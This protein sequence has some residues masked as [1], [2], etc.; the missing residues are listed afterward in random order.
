MNAPVR[1]WLLSTEEPPAVVEQLSELLDPAERARRDALVDHGVRAEFVLCRAALRQLLADALNTAPGSLRFEIGP[2][3]KPH[4]AGGAL[5]FN[6]SHSDGRAAI[7]LSERAVGVDI[8]QQRTG[9]GLARMAERYYAPT[10]AAWM[11][12]APDPEELGRRFSRLWSRKEACA[13]VTGGRLIPSLV[14][15]LS[16]FPDGS[17]GW[18]EPAVTGRDLVLSPGIHGA[19][20]MAGSEPF[21]LEIFRWAPTALISLD[22]APMAGTQC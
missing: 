12:S 1:V 15:P 9:I 16:T 14:W 7:A 11:R 4:L 21:E 10:E 5:Q 20:A 22:G 13:K 18:T 6:L 2:H 3:G 17:F 19:V 8:Q